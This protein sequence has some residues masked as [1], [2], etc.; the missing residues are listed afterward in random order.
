MRAAIVHAEIALLIALRQAWFHNSTPG[1]CR[2]IPLPRRH[3]CFQELQRGER[4]GHHRRHGEV[5]AAS[6]VPAR[7]WRPA[8]STCPCQRRRSTYPIALELRGDDAR[9]V[10]LPGQLP[11]MKVA[12]VAH[13]QVQPERRCAMR[14]AVHGPAT[15][16]AHRQARPGLSD[17][18]LSAED[19]PGHRVDERAAHVLNT[20]PRQAAQEGVQRVDR[21]SGPQSPGG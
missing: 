5:Q 1:W 18:A 11:N 16:V 20:M 9:C 2:S 6:P 3:P 7:C 12:Q 17:R 8:V 14:D 13:M 15:A 19:Q 10:D 21:R 4:A